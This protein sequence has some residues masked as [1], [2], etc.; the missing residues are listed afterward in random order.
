MSDT[1][2]FIGF[3]SS[4]YWNPYITNCLLKYKTNIHLGEIQFPGNQWVAKYY[5][6]MW[7]IF[8]TLHYEWDIW[9]WK[10]QGL[11]KSLSLIHWNT[12][13]PCWLVCIHQCLRCK[14]KPF[15]NDW[16]VQYYD[17]VVLQVLLWNLFEICSVT[18]NFCDVTHRMDVQ[19]SVTAHPQV[20]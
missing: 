10:G 20:V 13:E 2:H 18:R 4:P 14:M 11:E 17:I 16:F 15:T 7:Y 9:S 19:L 8:S 5:I 12:W 3:A 1:I 6:Y